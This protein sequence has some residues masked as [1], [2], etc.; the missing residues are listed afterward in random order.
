MVVAKALGMLAYKLYKGA[1]NIPKRKK[2]DPRFSNYIA[3]DKGYWMTKKQKAIESPDARISKHAR[4]PD[5][6]LNIDATTS[7]GKRI[8]SGITADIERQ[9]AR[10]KAVVHNKTYRK[11]KKLSGVDFIGGS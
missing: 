7:R 4:H 3:P 1:K 10:E 9:T 2:Y 11:K 8:H 5:S 6:K